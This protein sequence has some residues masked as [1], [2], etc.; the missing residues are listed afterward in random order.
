MQNGVPFFVFVLR[1][2]VCRSGFAVNINISSLCISVD[3]KVEKLG[4]AFV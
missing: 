2:C 1:G 3:K 4:V